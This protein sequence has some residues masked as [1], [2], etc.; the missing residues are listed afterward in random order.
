LSRNAKADPENNNITAPN[1]RVNVRFIEDSFVYLEIAHLK[2]KNVR[3]R[4]IVHKQKLIAT[5]KRV[6]S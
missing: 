6:F 2:V 4:L 3:E 5:H 1:K